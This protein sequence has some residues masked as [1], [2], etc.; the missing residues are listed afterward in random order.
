VANGDLT[1]VNIWDR[2]QRYG[3]LFAP[4]VRGG[5]TLDSAEQALGIASKGE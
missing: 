2:L 1:I 3:D 5:Q 4:V